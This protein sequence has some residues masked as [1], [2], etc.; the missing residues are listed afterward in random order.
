MRLFKDL[1]MG[2]F[3]AIN[4]TM[5][6]AVSIEYHGTRAKHYDRAV[7]ISNTNLLELLQEGAKGLN[8]SY[9]VNGV[10]YDLFKEIE[11]MTKHGLF[12]NNTETSKLR[13]KVAGI[14]ENF[15]QN[16]LLSDENRQTAQ[17]YLRMIETAD[18]RHGTTPA[19]RQ[20]SFN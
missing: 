10:T 9:Q 14:L 18:R 20:R 16:T 1:A 15:S 11:D 8:T 13:P 12:D 6:Y 19:P 17:D 4:R 3:N 7:A 5:N 2:A